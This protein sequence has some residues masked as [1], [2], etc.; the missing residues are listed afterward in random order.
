MEPIFKNIR[1][2]FE[3]RRL[4]LILI[5]LILL[6][7]S[8]CAAGQERT[9]LADDLSRDEL[10]KYAQSLGPPVRALPYEFNFPDDVRKNTAFG[11]DV[12]HYQGVID[13]KIVARQKIFF[14]YIKA[15]QG[16]QYFD[17]YFSKNW[18]GAANTG[19][20]GSKIHRGAYHFMTASD[21]PEKQAQNYISTVGSLG[22]EDLPPCIDV[23]WDFA[24][25]NGSLVRDQKGQPVDAW[26]SFSSD[27]VVRR[28]S[29]WLKL[30]QA[31][32]GRKPVIYTNAEWWSERI[33]KN[34]VLIHYP[35][36]VAD[37]TSKSLGSESPSVP[38]E[39][40]WSLWQLTD[41]GVLRLGGIKK[42]VDTT[43]YNGSVD[44]LRK[45]FGFAAS[46]AAR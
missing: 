42:P 11:I 22:S 8:L 10:A 16:D 7:T 19:D 13:W 5:D 41:Q 31:A 35:I 23:E 26:A 17:D 12:S 40:S 30:V 27:E 3:M 4:L 34:K 1:E 37:Y 38:P 6:S 46:P 14:V 9:P 2:R 33:G 32:T 18:A 28:I 44:K 29:T 45:Q 20:S 24:K 25:E 36:W 21:A 43:I 39:F 15:T